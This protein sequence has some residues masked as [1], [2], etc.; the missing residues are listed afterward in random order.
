M[1]AQLSDHQNKAQSATYMRAAA[2]SEKIDEALAHG[3][4]NVAKRL[5]LNA[6]RQARSG[7]Q[8]GD[9]DAAEMLCIFDY[10]LGLID[11]LVYGNTT[12]ALRQYRES[13][14]MSRVVDRVGGVW[15]N[16]DDL[17]AIVL[18][19]TAAAHL[20]YKNPRNAIRDLAELSDLNE[21]RI[22]RDNRAYPTVERDISSHLGG[23]A[24]G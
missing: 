3:E 6:K 11:Q 2:A 19:W 8:K 23:A 1:S 18:R 4:W 16:G 12:G 7:F 21:I 22:R 13:L 5:L 20:R 14:A 10:E 9:G 17:R 15:W 24:R